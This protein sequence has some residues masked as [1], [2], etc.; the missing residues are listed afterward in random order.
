MNINITINDDKQVIVEQENQKKKTIGKP[1]FV[2]EFELAN[3]LLFEGFQIRKILPNI[4]TNEGF[5]F[6][7]LNV[8]GIK[9]E[10]KKWNWARH[11]QM[12]E[13]EVIPETEEQNE[14]QE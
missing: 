13:D 3:H 2:Y 9:H 14:E 10:M 5:I 12:L 4:K 8:E 1:I 7:F 11:H 6:S